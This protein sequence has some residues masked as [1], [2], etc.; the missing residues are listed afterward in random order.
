MITLLLYYFVL[1]SEQTA[2]FALYCINWLDF[3]TEAGSVYCAVRIESLY[4][5]DTILFLTVNLTV[6]K[7]NKQPKT[8]VFCDK[9]VLLL[10]FVPD[11]SKQP[12]AFIFKLSRGPSSFTDLLT[13]EGEI[14]SQESGIL[15]IRHWSIWHEHLN[16][17]MLITLPKCTRFHVGRGIYTV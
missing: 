9:T 4:N 3:I 5:T 7:I 6:I 1:I 8:H 17:C 16:V 2:R 12:S 11:V 15:L 10:S 13:Y 14:P